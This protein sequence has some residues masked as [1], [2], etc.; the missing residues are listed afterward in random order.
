[1]RAI[2]VLIVLWP[3]F[4]IGQPGS[5]APE[6]LPTQSWRSIKMDEGQCSVLMPFEPQKLVDTLE[7][8]IGSIVTNQYYAREGPT[9]FMLSF[10]EYPPESLPLDSADFVQEFFEATIAESLSSTQGTLIYQTTDNFFEWPAQLWRLEFGQPTKGIKARGILTHH[11]F[12]LIQVVSLTNNFA[13]DPYPDRF[14]NSF[15]LNNE[16]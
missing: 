10:W 5:S 8:A 4:L 12:Y 1:M 16:P 3:V 6:I 7:A 2:F 14:I 9:T 13:S 15:K 11:R